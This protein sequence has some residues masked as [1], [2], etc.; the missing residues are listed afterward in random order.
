MQNIM[1][2]AAKFT[3]IYE[4]YLHKLYRWV[5]KTFTRTRRMRTILLIDCDINHQSACLTQANIV[6][7]T[8]R[9]PVQ[10]PLTWSALS[11]R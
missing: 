5:P 9:V 8:C 2:Q 1:P 6:F 7:N 10:D 11:I 3:G 4:L